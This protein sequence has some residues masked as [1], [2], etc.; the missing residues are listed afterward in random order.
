MPHL[1]G[2]EGRV[3]VRGEGV[4]VDEAAVESIA[5]HTVVVDRVLGGEEI[6]IRV[7]YIMFLPNGCP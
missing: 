6:D 1:E 5:A 2:L 4:D 7:P 3:L